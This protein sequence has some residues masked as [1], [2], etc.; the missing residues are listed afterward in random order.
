MS[1][2][3]NSSVASSSSSS[4][5]SPAS[6]PNYQLNIVSHMNEQRAHFKPIV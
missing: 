5:S 3:E 4:S 6:I 2:L 1:S